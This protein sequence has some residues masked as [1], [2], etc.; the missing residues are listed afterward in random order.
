MPL[1][2]VR[3]DFDSSHSREIAD[4][5]TVLQVIDQP[6]PACATQKAGPW[7]KPEGKEYLV[8]HY[9]EIAAIAYPVTDIARAPEVLR[10]GPSG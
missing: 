3:G 1:K 10:R 6:D 9:K 4:A 5:D 8:I 7:C 2:L